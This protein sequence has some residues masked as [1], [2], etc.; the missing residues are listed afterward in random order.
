MAVR[1]IRPEEEADWDAWMQRR[2]LVKQLN[3]HAKTALRAETVDRAHG[4]IENRSV[5]MIPI[6]PARPAGRTRTP[7][8]G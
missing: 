4:R 1:P 8:A 7:P 6:L 5:E 3:R 2:R